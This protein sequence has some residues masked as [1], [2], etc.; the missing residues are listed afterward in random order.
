MTLLLFLPLL[1][2][3]FF[4]CGFFFF[5]LLCSF[6]S[7]VFGPVCRRRLTVAGWPWPAAVAVAVAVGGWPETK[8]SIV[9]ACKSEIRHP[10]HRPVLALQSEKRF[11]AHAIMVSSGRNWFTRQVVHVRVLAGVAQETTKQG[12]CL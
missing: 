7:S 10:N 3:L 11:P 5:F 4:L 6:L 2:L 12:K 8:K 9:D 1:L